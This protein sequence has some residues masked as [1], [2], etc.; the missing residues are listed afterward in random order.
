MVI[1]GP[2]HLRENSSLVQTRFLE[3]P[4]C[5]EKGNYKTVEV[6]IHAATSRYKDRKL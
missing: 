5:D 1:R 2:A 6:L 4:K 3:A